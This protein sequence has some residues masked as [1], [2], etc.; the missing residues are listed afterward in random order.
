MN[1]CGCLEPDTKTILSVPRIDF[2]GIK[3]AFGK[4]CFCDHTIHEAEYLH[5]PK[6]GLN[7]KAH[8]TLT[9]CY[10]DSPEEYPPRRLFLDLVKFLQDRLDQHGTVPTEKRA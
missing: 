9:L 6:W 1:T 8:A 10:K 3:A 2:E 7:A 4:D 5:Q